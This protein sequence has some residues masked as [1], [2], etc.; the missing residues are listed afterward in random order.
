VELDTGVKAGDP[1]ILYPP[2]NVGD[3]GKV[4]VR[5]EAAAPDLKAVNH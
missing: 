1:V 2:V 5:T 3:G 4:Q